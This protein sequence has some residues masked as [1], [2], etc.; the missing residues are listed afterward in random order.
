M[1]SPTSLQKMVALFVL[2]LLCSGLYAQPKIQFDKK[3]HDFGRIASMK[4][5]PAVF[6]YTNT[7]DQPLAILM[8][9]GD[10]EIQV[11]YKKKYIKP[12]DTARITINPNYGKKGTFEEELQVIT[13]TERQS[14]PIRVKGKVV[15]LEECYPDPSNKDI[16]KIYVT[17]KQTGDPVPK[18]SIEFTYNMHNTF[19]DQTD[20]K[21]VL[22][23][24]LEIGK[25]QVAI[26]EPGYEPYSKD[27]FLK[28]SK[29]VLFFKLTPTKT[30]ASIADRSTTHT[31]QTE[32]S[33][34]TPAASPVDNEVPE[35]EEGQLS[36]QKYA[37]NNVVL[38]L[39]VSSSMNQFN[40]MDSLKYSVMHLVEVLRSIDHVS[41]I[42]YAKEPEVL[43]KSVTGNR[44]AH[45]KNHIKDL[46]AEGITNGVKGLKAAYSI[47]RQKFEKNGNNQIIIATDGKFTGRTYKAGELKNMVR[48]YRE[49]GIIISILGLGVN[50]KAIDLMQTLAQEGGGKYIHVS[51]NKKIQSVLIEEIKD[52]S[53][54]RENP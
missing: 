20:K 47:A 9:K 12:G 29:P 16:R 22:T 3:T 7:G 11:K 52:K 27:F 33:S 5:P 48:S 50:K 35:I 8:I 40:R 43:L 37:A 13:N 41:V 34:S 44:N 24:E 54:I 51:K 21:G 30:P 39:D 15:S 38:L 6:T 17:N 14:V 31:R 49:Q 23:R 42:T 46:K 28:K 1:T 18:A 19:G 36:K 2:S 45:I 32:V 10:K 53:H 26:D 25:Y 4:F